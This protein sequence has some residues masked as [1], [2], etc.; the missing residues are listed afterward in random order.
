MRLPIHEIED[1]L[2]N[3]WEKGCRRFVVGSPTGSGKSTQLPQILADRCVSG[4]ITVL[5]PRRLAARLLAR[6]VAAQRRGRVGDECGYQVRFES[7]ISKATRIRYVT[8]GILLRELLENPELS[9][10]DVV[11][12]D[13]FHE[14]HLYGDV[15]LARLRT[16]QEELQPDIGLIVM[17]ATLDDERLV[18]Y[19]NNAEVLRSEGRTFP[20]EI[21][22]QAYLRQMT[23]DEKMHRAVR[24]ALRDKRGVGNFLLFLPGAYEIR[25]TMDRLRRDKNLK[26]F[27]VC[28]LHG[29]LA[30]ADQD[31]AVADG[32]PRR[33]IVA[34]NIAETSIT[35]PGVDVV[36][37]SGLARKSEYDD[38]R[39]LTTLHIKPI[40]RSS[41]DQRAGRAGRVRPGY[42]LR[43]WRE[44]EHSHKEAHEIPEIFRTDLTELVLNLRACGLN[45]EEMDWLD[46]PD[47][48]ALDRALRRLIELGALDGSSKEITPLGRRM[49]R[50]PL[51]PR[52]ARALLEGASLE[53]NW[54]PLVAALM[55]S[56]PLLTNRSRLEDFAYPEDESDLQPLLRAW[57]MAKDSRFSLE[58]CR[59]RA[60][61]AGAAREVERLSRLFGRLAGYERVCS[62]EP[63]VEELRDILL[64]GF[65]D[66]IAARASSGSKVWRLSGGRKAQVAKDSVVAKRG[67]LLIAARLTEIEGREL[68]VWLGINTTLGEETLQRN[69]RPVRETSG[70]V[71]N[72]SA[73]RVEARSERW[74]GDLCLESRMGGTAN[75]NLAAELLAQKVLELD[76][77]LKKWDRKVCNWLDRVGFLHRHMPELGIP[78]FTSGD[79]ELVIAEICRGCQSYKEIKERDVWSALRQ[80]LGKA[81]RPLIDKF[82][83]EEMRLE[84]GKRAKVSYQTDPPTISMVLQRLYDVRTNP[85]LAQ[86]RVPLRVEI[87]APN[88]RPVQ[89]TTDLASFW[90][91]SYPEV[92]KQL[93]GRYPKHEWR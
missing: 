18:P 71:W 87:L 69:G 90:E 33:I 16:I 72:E 80:W 86:G 75:E 54:F 51:H 57:R 46:A 25:K 42:C 34:T 6:T 45:P 2:V 26:A 14:R 91:N 31:A 24:Q 23:I 49:S 53:A 78:E 55:E 66:Q 77:P 65:A 38:G 47:E 58:T 11:V 44:N 36:I 12:F 3:L 70:M 76:L 67:D 19:L 50:L 62:S 4:L 39:D 63:D 29:E 10:Q 82:A 88:Q 21:G 8:E 27:D 52:L 61:H 84:N 20:V 48:I 15:T 64:T 92:R 40:A 30:S 81:Q 22:Y 32:G 7:K 89:V 17:S 68:Q 9:G 1:D 5:Q 28:A 85:A 37:D 59:A 83:P 41:A 79:R 13:E 56:R 93:K 60:I 35:I 43:L 74:L 73:R